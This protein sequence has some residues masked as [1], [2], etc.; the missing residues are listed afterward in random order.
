MKTRV[1]TWTIVALVVLTCGAAYATTANEY[2]QSGRLWLFQGTLMG[3]RNSYAILDAG[4]NDAGC[5][6]C[7]TSRELIFFHA[8]SRISM[9]AFRNDGAPTNSAFELAEENGF[10]IT[11]N[12]LYDLQI[13]S[14]RQVNRYDAYDL[15]ANLETLIENTMSS[16]GTD[17]LTEIDSGYS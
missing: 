9:W 13:T 10:S 7:A 14:N 1:M 4:M 17:G 6:D 2:V 11:G 8:L 15:P 5:P 3:L 16:I 12:W